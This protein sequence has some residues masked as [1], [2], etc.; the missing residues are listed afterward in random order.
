MRS[1][2]VFHAQYIGAWDRQS[3]LADQHGDLPFVEGGELS[4]RWSKLH[5][6][7]LNLLAGGKRLRLLHKSSLDWP[8]ATIGKS[9]RT[10]VLMSVIDF[11]SG[12][13]PGGT[14]VL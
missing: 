5:I 14:F 7:H 10:K 9:V 4:C 8:K 11:P 1:F 13:R 3:I 12:H 6:D 2:A